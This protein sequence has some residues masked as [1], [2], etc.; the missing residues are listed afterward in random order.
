MSK[1]TRLLLASLVVLAGSVASAADGMD[2]NYKLV[3]A[4]PVEGALALIKFETK[5][6]K[7]DASVLSPGGILLKKIK[8]VSVEG[9]LIRFD[10]EGRTSGS[11]EGLVSGDA[12]PGSFQ[13]GTNLVAVKLIKTTDEKLENTRSTM[14]IPEF[15]E[16]QTF[17][18]APLRLEFRVK[19]EK[20]AEKKAELV[21]QLAE[22][23]EKAAIEVPKLYR[24]VMAEHADDTAALAAGKALLA[25]ADTKAT[26]E[27]ARKWIGAMSAVAATHGPRMA[28]DVNVQVAEALSTVTSLKE[29]GLQAAKTAE[30][31]LTD[32]STTEERIRVF[33]ALLPILKMNSKAEEAKTTEAQIAKLDIVLDK[34]YLLKVPPFK[35][36][37]FAG[38]KNKS[39]R[40]VVF[41]L[42]TGAQCPPCVA[43]D[44]AFD[45]LSKSYKPTELILLQYHLHIPRPD[46]M[47]NED[48]L[49]R[50]KFYSISGT[51]STVFNGKTP[52]RPN[53]GGMAD[54]VD[55]YAEYRD[56]IN[57][58]LDNTSDTKLKV[59]AHRVGNK[60]DIKAEVSGL[61]DPDEKKRLR[62]VLVEETIHYV[63]SNK[64]RFH[65]HVVRALPGGVE[66]FAL[67][68]ANS[69]HSATVNLDE[70][71][72]KLIKY[73]D[74]YAKEERA[75]P[76]SDRPLDLKH[77]K[78]VGLVQNDATKEI[79]QVMEIDVG[80][81]ATTRLDRHN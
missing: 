39:D 67:K 12:V 64:L 43:A 80:E 35:P 11:F 45:A 63:G 10:M 66:G 69:Q 4:G 53:G 74:T 32:K 40:K 68:E 31:S 23:K 78:V 81:E 13:I 62:L 26:P 73:L 6:G 15:D 36:A 14:R 47:T 44:V 20:D 30:A 16:A 55:R 22:A 1:V 70:L 56:V 54:S 65:H 2:G 38:R 51:P 29:V 59:T 79:V 25:N 48:T 60:I 42:F 77:L 24:K 17:T 7:I 8:N 61:K 75:F 37:M 41:E 72:A 50:A 3:Q 71:R 28:H 21:K 49:A 58:I 9:K 76:D 33:K 52:L 34:E 5:D 57:P 19:Q 27:E 18:F 46:P